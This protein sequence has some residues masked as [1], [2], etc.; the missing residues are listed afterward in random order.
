MKLI[1]PGAGWALIY[2]Q[3]YGLDV[4]AEAARA[5]LLARPSLELAM[6]RDFRVSWAAG[7]RVRLSLRVTPAEAER[8]EEG[9]DPLAVLLPPLRARSLTRQE[10]MA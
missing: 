3:L 10:L 5:I 8:I 6:A 1:P 7:G 9:A 2:D 4:T